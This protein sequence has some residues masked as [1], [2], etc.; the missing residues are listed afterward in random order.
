M[1]VVCLCDWDMKLIV[2]LGFSVFPKLT[3]VM[4]DSSFISMTGTGVIM[5]VVSSPFAFV[6]C[7][8]SWGTRQTC[9]DPVF[10]IGS[11][12]PPSDF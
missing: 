11:N 8:V 1:S 2:S 9:H 5:I 4:C 7:L 12:T 10:G 6:L 3:N